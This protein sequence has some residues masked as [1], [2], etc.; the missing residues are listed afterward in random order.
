MKKWQN[1]SSNISRPDRA[2]LE[3]LLNKR[4][5]TEFQKKVLLAVSRIRGIP[6]K[7]LDSNRTIN[8]L[9]IAISFARMVTYAAANRWQ[10]VALPDDR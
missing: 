7:P 2:R 5:L 6:L 9:S 3:E 4:K 8:Y 1:K 10:W